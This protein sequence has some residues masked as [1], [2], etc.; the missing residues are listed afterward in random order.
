MQLLRT[1]IILLVDWWKRWFGFSYIVS[2]TTAGNESTPALHDFRTCDCCGRFIPRIKL[3]EGIAQ[4]AVCTDTVAIGKRSSDG[5]VHMQTTR[6]NS[7]ENRGEV[8][9]LTK[10]LHNPLLSWLAL[11]LLLGIITFFVR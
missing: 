10:P 9:Q 11:L 2:A 5:A 4:C 6:Y 3:Q 8:Y 7:T 1:A